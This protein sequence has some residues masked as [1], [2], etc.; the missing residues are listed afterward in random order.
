MGHELRVDTAG[1]HAMATRWDAAVGALHEVVAPTGLGLSC[2]TSAAA[3]DAAHV[4]V[5]A[6]TAALAARVGDRAT[7]VTL[8]DTSYIA[9][10]AAST[11]A[12]AAIFQ[13][14]IRM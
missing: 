10:E 13:P 7:G 2:Q 4:D 6:F 12:L 3:V 8:A 11:T 9:Q 14:T 5:A 1:V